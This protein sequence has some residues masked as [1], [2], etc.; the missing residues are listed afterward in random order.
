M[1][2][3]Y[4]RKLFTTFAGDQEIRLIIGIAYLVASVFFIMGLKFMAKLNSQYSI[5]ILS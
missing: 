2:D 4:V 5:R 3:N 1:I